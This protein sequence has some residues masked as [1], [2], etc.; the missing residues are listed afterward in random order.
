MEILNLNNIKN[1]VSASRKISGVFLF[2]TSC[3]LYFGETTAFY[4]Y[5]HKKHINTFCVHNIELINGKASGKY[6]NHSALSG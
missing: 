2:N 1:A 3:L 6:S 5:N 4:F